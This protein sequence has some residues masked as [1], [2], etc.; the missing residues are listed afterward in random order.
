MTY[1]I[2]DGVPDGY[3]RAAH[4][5]EEI[6]RAKNRGYGRAHDPWHNFRAG[7][8]VG[9]P[10]VTMAYLR[11][12]EKMN[13]L[14][15]YL[16]DNGEPTG[17]NPREEALD[18]ANLLLILVALLDEAAGLPPPETPEQKAFSEWVDAKGIPFEDSDHDKREG[19]Q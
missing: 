13:R 2:R 19:D 3:A 10:A 12:S 4:D 17:V 14:A 9:V 8:A 6:V 11:A 5:A 1:T 15:H 7:A 18:G 16:N